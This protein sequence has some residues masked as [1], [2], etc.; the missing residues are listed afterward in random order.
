MPL[1]H[2]IQHQ[3]RRRLDTNERHLRDR[4]AGVDNM[5][6]L[7]REGGWYAVIR[8]SSAVS[9]EGL[10]V[11]L[12]REDEVIVHPG[13]FYDFPGDGFLVVSLL[14]PAGVFQAGIERLA[15]RWGIR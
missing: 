10:A 4:M 11:A 5:S 3:I 15:V 2:A 13:Y 8:V 14:P 7:L 12:V 6:V 1:R 9:D